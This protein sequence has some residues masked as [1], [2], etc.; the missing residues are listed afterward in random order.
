MNDGSVKRFCY[1]HRQ[2]ELLEKFKGRQSRCV[3]ALQK[4]RSKRAA[5]AKE[6]TRAQSVDDEDKQYDT[7]GEG[8]V[9]K[10][11]VGGGGGERGSGS[12]GGST[13]PND[14]AFVHREH[15]RELGEEK[16]Q[17]RKR[18]REDF[19]DSSE[20]DTSRTSGARMSCVVDV[21]EWDCAFTS[22]STLLSSSSRVSSLSISQG[23]YAWSE[24]AS[25]PSL[26]D[27]EAGT[28]PNAA[29]LS[30]ENPHETASLISHPSH[31]YLSR[32]YSRNAE[33]THDV[34]E[35]MQQ[36]EEQRR[37]EQR[38]RLDDDLPPSSTERVA[39]K[40]S[41]ELNS[42][43]V[44]E[45]MHEMQDGAE[46]GDVPATFTTAARPGPAA[47]D[48]DTAWLELFSSV[49]TDM[50]LTP[51]SIV[52][53]KIS[54][55]SRNNDSKDT[56]NGGG[57]GGGT[58]G[59]S[60]ARLA[61][62]IAAGKLF[63]MC[64]SDADDTGE[65]PVYLSRDGR[66][67]RVHRDGSTSLVCQLNFAFCTRLM[68]SL[69]MACSSPSCRHVDIVVPCVPPGVKFEARFH[70]GT[71]LRV[72]EIS[73]SPTAESK[74]DSAAD[75][76]AA[77]ENDVHIRVHMPACRVGVAH[78]EA[79]W[80][81]GPC[82]NMPCG[83]GFPL[84]LLP[85][86]AT[87]DQ[88][89]RRFH[90]S[91]GAVCFTAA[92]GGT[93]AEM[94]SRIK[95]RFVEHTGHTLHAAAR[96]DQSVALR[97]HRLHSL[98]SR[99]DLPLLCELIVAALERLEY[100]MVHGTVDDIE[101][102]DTE[103]AV[104]EIE[105]GDVKGTSMDD[106]KAD[107]GGV[108]KRENHSPMMP[109]EGASAFLRTMLMQR[110]RRK[111]RGDLR[112]VDGATRITH[113]D[114]GANVMRVFASALFHWF[115]AIRPQFI[116][117]ILG[118]F[119]WS[120]SGHYEAT[121]AQIVVAFTIFAL[122]AIFIPEELFPTWK[123]RS[124]T[125]QLQNQ[126]VYFNERLYKLTTYY[127]SIFVMFMSSPLALG[128]VLRVFVYESTS[129][130]GVLGRMSYAYIF[131]RGHYEKYVRL[132]SNNIWSFLSFSLFHGCYIFGFHR[133]AY[134]HGASYYTGDQPLP[135]M[136][137]SAWHV[138]SWVLMHLISSVLGTLVA[139][140]VKGKSWHGA[141]EEPSKEH[142]K[143]KPAAPKWE[144]ILEEEKKTPEE[145]KIV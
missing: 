57:G 26:D 74:C 86:E 103:E 121:L 104:K 30:M 11:S 49:W 108:I 120:P 85:D 84:L 16:Q 139:S 105:Q 100:D 115:T 117:Q 90:W 45:M 67:V 65:P 107:K 138:A 13:Q 5:K 40:V 94:Q 116:F 122:D 133:F 52:L 69:Q 119:W 75:A 140:M 10:Q 47:A 93:S 142:T 118:F 51:G 58:A 56:I 41:T 23:E 106:L 72:D 61:R 70:G 126:I 7:E 131:F 27:P 87:A 31:A 9:P 12:R 137:Q 18:D 3:A 48:D 111:Q 6:G 68:S 55:V 50:W 44:R 33:Q 36:F 64:E 110:M 15:D 73:R 91:G 128:I 97:L 79:V 17:Q 71:L 1:G 88:V 78:I 82:R 123:S 80:S 92:A 102:E 96:G 43:V 2:F 109:P 134:R 8:G 66:A 24:I 143:S 83:A 76:D 129:F 32:H 37:D 20:G 127:S 35:L 144:T 42:D 101:A 63:K 114:P 145:K 99:L 125:A 132:E 81:D 141:P 34:L 54:T 25:A 39:M 124:Q 22:L 28:A 60:I 53:H 89:R 98:A 113:A 112:G 38:E 4:I 62:S 130:D 14:T 95:R 135:T 21:D 19:P 77:A 136:R 46:A 29:T 59:G